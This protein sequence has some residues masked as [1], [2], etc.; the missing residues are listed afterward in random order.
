[1]VKGLFRPEFSL[2]GVCYTNL[3]SK[4]GIQRLLT[5]A[6]DLNA[7]TDNGTYWYLTESVPA[8]APY[9]NASVVEVCGSTSDATQKIQRATRYGVVGQS[10]FRP[11]I[12]TSGWLDWA[13]HL[14][15]ADLKVQYGNASV[16][17]I[18]N[19]TIEFTV[20]FPTPFTV[21]PQVMVGVST[22][23]PGSNS[24]SV[25]TTSTTQFK[26]YLY[27]SAAASTDIGVKWLA[28][29]K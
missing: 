5:S 15:D 8:H 16:R 2:F 13:Y 28:V 26:G 18:Q 1:M 22:A 3:G 24:V 27:R 12:S 7:I 20:K 10:A 23:V 19:E 17:P 21:T 25:L 9:I 29:G 4:Y 11:L 14:T 6:D